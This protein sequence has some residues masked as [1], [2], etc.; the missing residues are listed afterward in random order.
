MDQGIELGWLRLTD[1]SDLVLTSLNVSQHQDRGI[2]GENHEII[3]RKA[4]STVR[5]SWRRSRGLLVLGI[6]LLV[7]YLILLISPIIAGPV[8]VSSWE[9]TLN[10]SSSTVSF[11]E[12][13]SLLGGSGILVLFWFY[14]RNEIQIMAPTTTLEGIPRSYE[15]AEKFCALVVSELKD[16]PRPTQ[17]TENEAESSPKAADHNWRL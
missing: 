5:I 7:T 8:G 4:I 1:K 15:E 10:L 2:F 16:Q 9:Q 11:I 17:K 6:I 3:P 12:Y 13:G 14:K